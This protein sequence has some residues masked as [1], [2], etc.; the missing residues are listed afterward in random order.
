MTKTLSLF[1]LFPLVV[2]TNESRAAELWRRGEAS[3]QLSGSLREIVLVT[4]QTDRDEFLKA[5]EDNLLQCGLADFFASCP[6]FDRVGEREVGQSLTRLRTRLDL[7]MTPRL[8]ASVSYDHELSAGGIDTLE[9]GLGRS[10]ASDSFLG[11]EH[12]ILD[13]EN[14][15]WRHLLYR[16]YLQFEGVHLEGVVGRQRVAWGV[17]RLWNPIDRFNPVPPLAVE[18]DQSGGVDAVD[19]KWIID[20]LHFAEVVYA[21]GTSR[22]E[23]RYALRLHAVLFDTDL[24][25]MGGVFEKAPTAGFDLSR[26]LGDAALNLEVVYTDP[27]H[28]VWPVGAVGPREPDPFWQVAVSIDRNVDLGSGL[29]LL[30]E[31][32]YNGNALGFGRGRAG[33]LL[34]FF[35]STHDP[36]VP[37]P[38]PAPPGPFVRPASVDVFGSS[39]VISRAGHQ[40]ALELGYD[41]TPELRLDLLTIF[42]WNG[43]SAAFF[44]FLRYS[45]LGWLELTLGTQYFVGPRLSE[46]GG[47]EDLVYL[48][49][50]VF[51]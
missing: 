47:A 49:T 17:A 20:G 32:L 23:A 42:D 48:L 29:Y 46:Y 10:V 45:P 22:D 27:E 4:Q 2:A 44:P 6:A 9:V 11:A 7:Q 38:A 36:P 34:P 31:H 3:L 19:L 1:L 33:P 28:D 50:E 39:G 43:E 16:A 21:P 26:N 15:R 13:R 8:S 24:S 51:F 30:V 25:L 35:E 41:L 5:I 40:T 12:D 37:L 14:V 18:A